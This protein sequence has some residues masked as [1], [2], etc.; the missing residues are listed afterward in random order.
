MKWFEADRA[1]Y[2]CPPDPLS[3]DPLSLAMGARGH[4]PVKTSRGNLWD[5]WA[6]V[7]VESGTRAL[8][9]PFGAEVRT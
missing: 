8:R 9:A 2:S 5:A 3:P 4:R 6:I 7:R 1:A